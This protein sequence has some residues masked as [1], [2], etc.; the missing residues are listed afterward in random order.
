MLFK[1]VVIAGQEKGGRSSRTAPRE[2]AV[3]ATSK[4]HDAVIE[5]QGRLSGCNHSSNL[6]HHDLLVYEIKSANPE[7]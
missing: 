7:D 3:S 6:D 1:Q 2:R 4:E 5:T